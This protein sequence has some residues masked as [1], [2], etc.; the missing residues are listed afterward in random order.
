MAASSTSRRG[1]G[2]LRTL[3]R[4]PFASLP[5]RII[6]LVFSA[7]L[8][9]S[10][11]VTW[12]PRATH[13]LRRQI[14]SVPARARAGVERC[15]SGTS[16]ASAYRHLSRSETVISSWM[17]PSAPVPRRAAISC[18]C[19]RAS[20]VPRALRAGCGRRA[21]RL[22]RQTPTLP[23]T[24]RPALAHRRDAH[25]ASTGRRRAGAVR[26][27]AA[28]RTGRATGCSRDTRGRAGPVAGQRRTARRAHP[29]GDARRVVAQP[30]KSRRSPPCRIPG[31]RGVRVRRR[32]G[33]A[34]GRLTHNF[35][36]FDWSSSSRSL[37]SPSRRSWR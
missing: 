37:R 11:A 33:H 4:R 25:G 5:S 26:L 1:L 36:L 6:P 8:A 14:T 35:D 15:S 23:A 24:H 21:A 2:L 9:A 16:S 34:L 12:L 28:R 19:A 29:R 7:A 30:A 27:D 13:F 31:A 3:A 18:T 17:R 32:L 10:A 22:G 20:A